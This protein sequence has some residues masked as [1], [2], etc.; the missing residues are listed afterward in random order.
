LAFDGR[1]N[2]E[3][4]MT[5]DEKYPFAARLSFWGGMTNDDGGFS[6][7]SKSDSVSACSPD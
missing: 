7:G 3:I 2:D 6:N 5:N 1:G 4:R